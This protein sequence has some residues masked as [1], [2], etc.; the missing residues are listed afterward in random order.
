MRAKKFV[1]V[2]GWMGVTLL[3]A[4]FLF[5]WCWL[6][7]EVAR[8]TWSTDRYCKLEFHQW[9][10]GQSILSYYE[11]GT[12]IGFVKLNNDFLNDPLAMFPGPDGKS[13]V[14]LSWPDTFDA[15]FTVSFSTYSKKGVVIPDRLK[16][17]G[18][19]AVDFS[20]FPVRACT[21]REVEFVRHFI[22]NADD[23]T[24]ISC[25]RWQVPES[26]AEK[27]ADTLR[28]LAW[29]TSPND[30]RD[31]VLKDGSPLILPD[32]QPLAVDSR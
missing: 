12:R 24:L 6:S 30:W 4:L 21:T 17:D 29:A 7:S 25:L 23:K 26:T 8:V 11:K 32:D 14:C 9:Y 31:S 13:V 22:Q 15:A 10:S 18:Q 27:R 16:L 3:G 19:E 1:K 2:L 20:N 5:Y 28:F